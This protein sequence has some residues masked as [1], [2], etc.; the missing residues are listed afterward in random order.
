MNLT[1]GIYM[2]IVS[3]IALLGGVI[4]FL[5]RKRFSEA[6]IVS[7]REVAKR[8]IEEAEQKAEILKKEALL[9]VKD[10]L[11]Q[12]KAEFEKET[13]EKRQELQNLEKRIIQRESNLDKKIELLDTKE[14]DIVRREKNLMQQEK[15]AQE[16]EKKVATLLEKQ[17]IQLENIAKMSSEEAKRLLMESMEE[18]AKHDA[19]KRIKRIEEE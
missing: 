4:G 12:E 3:V 11:Y 15:V 10:K 13:M 9:Q 6:R 19:A 14:G 5:V 2:F 1:V 7:A 8:L 17:R 18:E 16:Q